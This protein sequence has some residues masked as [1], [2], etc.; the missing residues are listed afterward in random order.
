MKAPSLLMAVCLSIFVAHD[1]G[2]EVRTVVLDPG[3]GG[4]NLGAP[5]P[6]SDGKFEKYYTLKLATL[7]EAKLKRS[8]VRVELT[9]RDD[10]DVPL[11]ERVG[12]AN[13]LNADVFVSLHL[14][15]T[16]KA[17]PSGHETYFLSLEATDEA[18]RRL[19]HLESKDPT[20]VPKGTSNHVDSPVVKDI[21]LDLKRNQAHADA[22]S[23]AAAIQRNTS[24]KSPFKNRGVKQAPFYVLM[25]AAMPA[26]VIEIG[27]LNHPE[28]G[29]FIITDDGLDSMADGI[30]KGIIE[31][32]RQVHQR[33]AKRSQK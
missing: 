23:L 4:E 29:R 25:G 27:F 24:P 1:S 22:Q 6:Y 20:A 31:Y 7:V 17:G 33:R 18:A 11:I 13:R 15:S 14:N 28:E 16:D 2:A 8:G 21:L 12:L 19:A 26:V 32:G 5:A 10:R 9:R 30:A 3:H